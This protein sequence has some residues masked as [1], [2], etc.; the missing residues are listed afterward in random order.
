MFI[1]VYLSTRTVLMQNFSLLGLTLK[2]YPYNNLA[3][4]GLK[5]F[6]ST[7]CLIFAYFL[8]RGMLCKISAVFK[9][10]ETTL[11]I[12]LPIESNSFI[13][14]KLTQNLCIFQRILKR[15]SWNNF[16]DWDWK[17]FSRVEAWHLLIWG[18]MMASFSLYRTILKNYHQN[19]LADWGFKMLLSRQNLAQFLFL[20]LVKFGIRTRKN[21]AYICNHYF[22][23]LF[24]WVN[25]KLTRTRCII[26]RCVQIVQQ[27]RPLQTLLE[28]WDMIRS[29]NPVLD[30]TFLSLHQQYENVCYKLFVFVLTSV[31][32]RIKYISV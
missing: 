9:A 2:N 32:T 26:V 10:T 17:Y 4:W 1:L 21:F 22:H 5:I 25:L 16:A 13:R 14:K 29:W 27:S 8:I 23:F 30:S 6:Q 7:Q 19:N 11:Q 20:Y 12:G 15:Y 3:D 24:I 31:V 18:V 28:K